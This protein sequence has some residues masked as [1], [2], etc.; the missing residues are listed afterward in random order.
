MSSTEKGFSFESKATTVVEVGSVGLDG[1]SGPGTW[2]AFLEEEEPIVIDLN[3][4][5]CCLSQNPTLKLVS[6]SF[7]FSFSQIIR[8]T[9]LL[10]LASVSSLEKEEDEEKE[11]DEKKDKTGGR[12]LVF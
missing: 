8:G 6:I 2:R 9:G 11:K 4:R 12:V 7:F 1:E 5:L 10:S 3:R